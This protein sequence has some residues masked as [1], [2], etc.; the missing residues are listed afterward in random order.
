MGWGGSCFPKDLA[1]L[2][3]TSDSNGHRPELLEA[4][5]SVN[6]RQRQAVVEKLERHLGDLEGCRVALL[7]LAFKPG[8]DDLRD[9][10][11]LD[12]AA[13]LVER[14]AAVIA[15]DPAV[16]S[17][18]TDADCTI[19]ANPYDAAR[20][21]DAVVLITDWPEYGALDLVK[22]GNVMAGEL[23][24]DGRNFIEPEEARAAGLRYEGFGRRPT[25]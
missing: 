15:H 14:G 25:P 10:P 9:A 8:T 23:L 1:A 16:T 20:N 11:S 5:R 22:L 6:Q 21:A 19:A 12:I 17:V 3:A 7:G 18:S 4:V 13:G 24:I 2:V